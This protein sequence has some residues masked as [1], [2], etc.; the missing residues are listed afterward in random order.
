M[1]VEDAEIVDLVRFCLHQKSR[2][3]PTA[4]EMLEHIPKHRQRSL[5]LVSN[6][7]HNSCKDEMS[8]SSVGT[9]GEEK[10]VEPPVGTP[11]GLPAAVELQQDATIA[12]NG[13][14]QPPEQSGREA[15]DESHNSATAGDARKDDATVAENDGEQPSEQSRAA[16]M[17]PTNRTIAPQQGK[18]GKTMQLSPRTTMNSRQSRA[19]ATEA[20]RP[21]KE[22]RIRRWRWGLKCVMGSS[23]PDDDPGDTACSGLYKTRVGGLPRWTSLTLGCPHLLASPHP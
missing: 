4:K 20:T 3:R 16:A 7:I 19:A 22:R 2:E 21:R 11:A 18:L 1:Q 13:D 23:D 17:R 6:P 12:D 5:S 15:A 9:G 10:E 8:E 14:E